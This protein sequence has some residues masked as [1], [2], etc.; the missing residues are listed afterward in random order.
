V[1]NDIQKRAMDLQLAAAVI[2]D[3]AKLP[4]LV[5]EKIHP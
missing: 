4:E 2:V 3:E 5:H 1:E